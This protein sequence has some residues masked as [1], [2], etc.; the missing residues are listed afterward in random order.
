MVKSTVGSKVRN[1]ETCKCV[2]P[3]DSTGVIKICEVEKLLSV[4][5]ITFTD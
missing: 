1:D 5:Q 2:K 4:G 3:E